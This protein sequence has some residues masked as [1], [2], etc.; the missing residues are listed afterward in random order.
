MKKTMLSVIIASSVFF[1]AGCAEKQYVNVTYE[2]QANNKTGLIRAFETNGHTVLQFNDVLV[3]NPRIYL[4]D[5]HTELKYAVIGQQMADIDGVY[6]SLV[7][8]ALGSE[9][10][11]TSKNSPLILNKAHNS[12]L[13]PLP[14]GSNQAGIDPEKQKLKE[15]LL[16]VKKELDDI[17]NKSIKAVTPKKDIDDELSAVLESNNT[18]Q[19]SNLTILHFH[20]N[21]SKIE[22]SHLESE[23]IKDAI[24]SSHY[25]LIKG[26]TDAKKFSFGNELIA[27]Q[28][29]ENAKDLLVS[30]GANPKKIDTFWL[31]NGDFAD[32]T[33]TEGMKNRRVEISFY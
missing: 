15:E 20:K 24:K 1:A 19:E 33:D 21:E 3:S 32:P 16:Q 2:T 12:N 25:V 11:V 29:A 13:S 14:A 17:K 6:P 7:V 4:A 31:A 5:T 8:S 30:L 18:Q 10:L 28:R 9:T 27:R 23:R 26:R 22:I